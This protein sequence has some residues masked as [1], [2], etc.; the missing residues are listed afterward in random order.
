MAISTL[1]SSCERISKNFYVEILDCTM[2]R[3]SKPQR[4]V[5]SGSQG[6]D[7]LARATFKAAPL[8]SPLKM[9]PFETGRAA[10]SIGDHPIVKLFDLGVQARESTGDQAKKSTGNQKTIRESL[11]EILQADQWW[12]LGVVRIGFKGADMDKCPATILIQVKPSSMATDRA[13]EI[14]QEAAN[15]LYPFVLKF[16][17]LHSPPSC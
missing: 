16:L 13:V 2:E 10:M 14:V 8:Q 1:I 11:L 4:F 17:T 3:A 12:F 7:F 5:E 15:Y 9:L 6:G